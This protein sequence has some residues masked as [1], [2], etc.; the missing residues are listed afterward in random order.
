MQNQRPEF[1][2]LDRDAEIY[3]SRRRLPHWFQ[4]GAALFV[5]FRT[6]DSLPRSALARMQAELE[7]WLRIRE[8]PTRLASSVVSQRQVDHAQLLGG[9]ASKD[10]SE[11][12]RLVN[13]LH[14][15][16]LDECLGTCP[17]KQPEA[18]ELV[19]NVL[20]FYDG[21]RYDL[22]RFVVMP[23]HI[24]VI[25]QF[26][27]GFDLSTIGQSWMRYSARQINRSSAGQADCGNPQ[28]LTTLFAAMHSSLGFNN[29]W[30]KNPINAGLSR[31]RVLF[32][33]RET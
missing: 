33:Q 25:V 13:R 10:R 9:L 27:A 29:T 2:V 30:R 20:R 26:Y 3:H 18:T 11:F 28:C 32:W 6:N 15:W 22:E 12:T 23:N 24:H 16:S 17:F 8:L 21:I 1:H 19:A 14:H 4:P 5:T 31:G 7:E